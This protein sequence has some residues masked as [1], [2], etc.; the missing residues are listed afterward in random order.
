MTYYTT[1][2][3]NKYY[4]YNYTVCVVC[5]LYVWYAYYKY[6]MPTISVY[7]RIV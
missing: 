7:H 6:G 1:S 2:Y 3:I 4:K 5:L